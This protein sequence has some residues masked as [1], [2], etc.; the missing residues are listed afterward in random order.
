MFTTIVVGNVV[1]KSA[2]RN[3]QVAG[4][5]TPVIDIRIAARNGGEKV[6]FVKCVVWG[7]DAL[8]VNEHLE[9]GRTVSVEGT[10]KAQMWTDP[11]GETHVWLEVHTHYV[12]FLNHGRGEQAGA[13]TPRGTVRRSRVPVLG[14]SR[15]AYN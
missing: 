2:L 12:E 14:L 11:Q 4:K 6:H 1:K 10:P 8:A 9:V 13:D 15:P 5:S 3:V 7:N